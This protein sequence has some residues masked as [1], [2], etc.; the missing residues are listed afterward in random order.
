LGVPCPFCKKMI[1]FVKCG[2]G[3]RSDILLPRIGGPILYPV[4]VSYQQQCTKEHPKLILT[5]P[6]FQST[7]ISFGQ[8]GHLQMSRIIGSSWS[9]SKMRDIDFWPVWEQFKRIHS[10]I[11]LRQLKVSVRVLA[12]LSRFQIS[13]PQNQD[14]GRLRLKK[15]GDLLWDRNTLSWELTILSFPKCCATKKSLKYSIPHCAS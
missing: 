3:S 2:L 14:N 12:W 7:L 15:G 4:S 10:E 1:F 5:T 11:E 13:L 8:I 6:L 9:S